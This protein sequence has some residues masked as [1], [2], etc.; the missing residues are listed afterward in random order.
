MATARARYWPSRRKVSRAF[1]SP[2]RAR[3]AISLAEGALPS[4]RG[5]PPSPAAGAAIQVPV[6]EACAPHPVG[7]GEVEEVVYPL[8]AAEHPLRQG[9]GLSVIVHIGGQAV[10]LG[11]PLGDLEKSSI[12]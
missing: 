10:A 5:A 3:R 11:Q 1:S 12:C 7:H 2:A 6:E 4:G 9:A 8:A